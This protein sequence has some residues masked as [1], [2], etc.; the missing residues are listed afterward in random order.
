MS[1][2]PSM[3]NDNAFLECITEMCRKDPR[4]AGEAYFFLRDALDA[5]TKAVRKANKG[6]GRHITGKELIDHIRTFALREFGPMAF[7]VFRT[8][9]ITRTE[10]FG[11]IVFNLVE[12]GVLGKTEE[13]SKADFAGGYDFT[14]AFVKPFL[15]GQAAPKDKG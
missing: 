12:A 3:G 13:D 2:A 7:T 8:W 5:A 1:A 10:D 9:G 15:P 4:Y 11:E 14:D 6:K